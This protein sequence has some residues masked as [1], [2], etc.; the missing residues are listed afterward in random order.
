MPATLIQSLGAK[1]IALIE[2]NSFLDNQV[3]AMEV[4]KTGILDGKYN[5]WNTVN[6]NIIDSMI[7]DRNDDS[8]KANYI[9]FIPFI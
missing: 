3:V 6:T 7:V 2:Y 9:E 1:E 8:S 4:G 5:F